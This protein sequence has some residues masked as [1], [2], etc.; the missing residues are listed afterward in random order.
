MRTPVG[1]REDA[2]DDDEEGEGAI[3]AS[4]NDPDLGEQAILK[5]AD[6]YQPFAVFATAPFT[7]TS[8]VALV[9]SGEESDFLF[10]PALGAS[11]TP[12]LTNQLFANVAVW[13]QW[14]LYNDFSELDFASFDARVGLIY[15]VPRLRNLI[16]RLDYDYNRLTQEDLSDEFFSDH[17]IVFGGEIPVRIGR[18]Q[19]ITGGADFS[20]SFA[21]SPD[22][23]ARHDYSTFVAYSVL[24]T[25]DL[26]VNAVGRIAVRD[27]VEGGRVDL[28]G[29]LSLG[30]VYRFNPWLSASA[31][32]TFATNESN[33]SVF[34]YDVFNLG[35]ALSVNLRY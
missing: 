22:A 4:P 35:G 21:A 13:Q 1:L 17:S 32:S 31:V 10:T 6:R 15:T 25:R 24:L 14:F 33:Q 30:A 8:N 3:V 7:Y 11:Y 34:D 28:S 19:Q 5:R 26:T 20:F 12:R 29:I 2:T 16:L 18:A 9:R 23:P 27:Y